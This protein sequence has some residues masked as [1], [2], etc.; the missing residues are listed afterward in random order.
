[1]SSCLGPPC[2]LASDML[3][4]ERAPKAAWGI[5]HYSQ[6][7]VAARELRPQ[8]RSAI[9]L[10]RLLSLSLPISKKVCNVSIDLKLICLSP[11]ERTLIRFLIEFGGTRGIAFGKIE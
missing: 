5:R 7:F 9:P 10:Q 6:P 4:M 8:S 2:C 11:R 3:N 1:L